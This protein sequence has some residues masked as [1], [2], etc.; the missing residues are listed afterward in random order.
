[1]KFKSLFLL[2]MCL[3]LT[4]S[5]ATKEPWQQ[6]IHDI[7]DEIEN[8]VEKNKIMYPFEQERAKIKEQLDHK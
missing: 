7:R 6:R 5:C 1:M 4:T 8:I 2:V 3:V